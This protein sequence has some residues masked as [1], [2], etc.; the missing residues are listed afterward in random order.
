M[1]RKREPILAVLKYFEEVDPLLIP[2]GVAL[3]M[4]IARRRLGKSTPRRSK[5]K[6]AKPTPIDTAVN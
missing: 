3:V 1:S 6:V 2:Q 4:A 5:P